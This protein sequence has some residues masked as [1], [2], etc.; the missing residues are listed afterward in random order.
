MADNAPYLFMHPYTRHW[1]DDFREAAAALRGAAG[2]LALR[3]DHIGSTSVPALCSKNVVDI[4]LTVADL[5]P[6]GPL[7]IAL[8]RIGFTPRAGTFIDHRPPGAVGP[9]SDW[10]KRYFRETPPRR[11]VHLHVRAGGRPNQRY[12]LLF[13]DYLRAHPEAAEAYARTKQQLC[14]TLNGNIDAYIAIKD[15]ICDLIYQAAEA[16]AVSTNWS[17]GPSDA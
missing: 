1:A 8:A 7:N 14:A 2:D 10:A 17:P 4:Q 12:P 9:D 13:R 3:V 11:C 5:D 15:P 6:P 16:W